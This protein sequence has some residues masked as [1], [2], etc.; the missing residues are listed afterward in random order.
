M[1]EK[2][3]LLAG[4]AT[5]ALP[6]T[7]AAEEV[8]LA[9]VGLGTSDTQAIRAAVEE[10]IAGSELHL[11]DAAATRASL[12][13]FLAKPIERASAAEIRSLMRQMGVGELLLLRQISR[14]A[15]EKVVVFQVQ[16]FA[17][18]EEPRVRVQ[19]VSAAP[20]VMAKAVAS[21]LVDLL[22]RQEVKASEEKEPSPEKTK[23][24]PER[25]RALK[26]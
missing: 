9:L 25:K 12:R 17:G 2:T 19:S 15:A 23:F 10:R 18:D 20:E 24:K 4:L 26:L 7:A 21:L 22:P 6:G 5:L 11:V 1:L 3:A 13:A 16:V 14:E 8:A